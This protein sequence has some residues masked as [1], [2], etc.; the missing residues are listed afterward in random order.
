M[1]AENGVG[2]QRIVLTARNILQLGDFSGFGMEDIDASPVCSHPYFLF[3]FGHAQYDV[4]AQTGV[5][6]GI[7]GYQF[8]LGGETLDAI[9]VG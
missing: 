3:E 4:T 8:S 1:K 9:V 7:A 6:S 5:L 2:R